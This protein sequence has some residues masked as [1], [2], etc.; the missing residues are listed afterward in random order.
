MV[1]SVST[2]PGSGCA[3]S[4]LL[5]R[6]LL[7]GGEAERGVDADRLAVEVV[8]LNDALHQV[9]VLRRAAHALRERDALAEVLRGLLL[10]HAVRRGEEGAG[11]D[12]VDPDATDREVAGGHD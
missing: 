2:G 11:R 10:R 1:M 9:C 7:L 4:R 8:V 3:T 6:R 12:A 5:R